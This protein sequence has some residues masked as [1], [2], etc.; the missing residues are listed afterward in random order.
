MTIGDQLS[1][2]SQPFHRLSLPDHAVVGHVLHYARFQDEET[3]VDPALADLG[4]LVKM[5]HQVA[6]EGDAAEA[7]RRPH[8]GHRRQLA[9]AAMKGQELGEVDAGHAVPVGQHERLIA[10]ELGHLLHPAAGLGVQA[11]VQQVNGPVF[12]VAVMN[13]DLARSQAYRHAVGAMAVV[14]EEIL[15]HLTLVAQRDDELLEAVGGVALHDVPQDRLAPDFH[16]RL[17]LQA[18]F[19]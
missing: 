1:V 16:H 12:A 3:A 11:G 18:G 17:G 14:D 13:S 6:V 7:C 19:L 5:G 2:G 8:R 10:D 15:D 9:V 4:L